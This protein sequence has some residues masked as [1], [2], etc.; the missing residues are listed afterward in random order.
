MTTSQDSFFNYTCKDLSS[1]YGH[2][3]N[4]QGL[5]HIFW[6]QEDDST[7]YTIPTETKYI[8]FYIDIKM[9]EASFPL[10]CSLKIGWGTWPPLGK[11]R[12]SCPNQGSA[13]HCSWF[14]VFRNFF[15]VEAWKEAMGMENGLMEFCFL[16]PGGESWRICRGQRQGRLK[17]TPTLHLDTGF[18]WCLFFFFFF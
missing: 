9:K 5:G 4:F 7:H 10:L 17:E 11:L 14:S 18:I 13:S 3:H 16:G 8:K 6:G 15:E 1:E 2:I 12:V